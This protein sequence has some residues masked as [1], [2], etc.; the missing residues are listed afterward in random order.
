ML[1]VLKYL[2][3]LPNT[4]LGALFM[5]MAILSGG[6]VRFIDGVLE[7][8]GRAISWL[9]RTAVPL[10]GGASAI[11]LGHVVLGRNEALL[12]CCRD[13]ERVHV[14]QYEYWGPLFLP[15]YFIAGI[16]AYA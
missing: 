14:R 3:A 5:P 4:F 13:H 12:E 1:A 2:W 8:H 16:L 6:K 15:A 10:R 9:L 7:V 11:T